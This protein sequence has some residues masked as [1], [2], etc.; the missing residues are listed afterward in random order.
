[1]KKIN[2]NNKTVKKKIVLASCAISL[3]FGSIAAQ[4][5]PVEVTSSILAPIMYSQHSQNQAQYSKMNQSLD[6]IS[7]LLNTNF[8]RDPNS[9]QGVVPSLLQIQIEALKQLDANNTEIVKNLSN[10]MGNIE[11]TRMEY[12]DEMDRMPDV[13][14]NACAEVTYAPTRSGGGATTSNVAKIGSIRED[15]KRENAEDSD[16]ETYKSAV[17]KAQAGFCTDEEIENG[18][19]ACRNPGSVRMPNADITAGSL[20]KG[21]VQ[22]GQPTNMSLNRDQQKAAQAYASNVSVGKYPQKVDVGSIGGQAAYTARMARYD[23]SADLYNARASAAFHAINQIKAFNSAPTQEET[24]QL[25]EQ[26]KTR[27]SR[28]ADPDVYKRVL[29]GEKFPEVPSEKEIL[30]YDVMSDYADYADDGIINESGS[31]KGQDASTQLVILQL[32]ANYISYLRLQRQEEANAMLAALVGQS[33]N[34][35]QYDR[36]ASEADAIGISSGG[37]I[38]RTASGN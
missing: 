3:T 37:L 10:A 11:K 33:L 28:S 7:Y 27:W 25:Y 14:G 2:I 34:G 4:A 8:S 6:A 26:Q 12:E 36:L 35:V 29:P 9:A 32:K 21:A 16:T 13:Y 5:F 24:P 19:G 30:R 20:F 15:L 22:D 1:M 17:A 23:E 38:E 18:K 31:M